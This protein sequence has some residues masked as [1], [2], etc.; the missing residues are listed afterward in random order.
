MSLQSLAIV[1]LTNHHHAGIFLFTRWLDLYVAILPPEFSLTSL[2]TGA[3]DDLLLFGTFRCAQPVADEAPLLSTL[4]VHV[5]VVVYCLLF[6]FLC[7]NA[8]F[9][10]SCGG[11]PCRCFR[12]S[13]FACCSCCSCRWSLISA[14]ACFRLWF[15]RTWG[16][17]GSA[18]STKTE[19][20]ESAA[21]IATAESAATHPLFICGAELGLEGLPFSVQFGQ[22]FRLFL[23]LLFER[24]R[25]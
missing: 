1:V 14:L 5:V 11:F 9:R 8:C 18:G 22:H 16:I 3:S 20:P 19:S 6:I 2:S 17:A 12:C 15:F 25:I 23:P 4:V 10:G 13:C 21:Q 7:R 24:I